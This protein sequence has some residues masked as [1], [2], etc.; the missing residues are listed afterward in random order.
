MVNDHEDEELFLREIED[1]KIFNRR[2]P[3]LEEEGN[4]WQR[5]EDRKRKVNEHDKIREHRETEP[6]PK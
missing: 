1:F 6:S 2:L 5:I 4:I 3:T